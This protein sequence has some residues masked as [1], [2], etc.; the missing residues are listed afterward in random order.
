VIGVVVAELALLVVLCLAFA[1]GHARGRWWSTPT[2][3]HLMLM[4]GTLL[5]MAVSLL[6]LAAGPTPPTWVFALVFGGTDAVMVGWLVLL[7][8]ARRAE[9]EES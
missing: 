9:T 8:R 2:G 6:L 3:R 7:R 1:V 4:T 5:A